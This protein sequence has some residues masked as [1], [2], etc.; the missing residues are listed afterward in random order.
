[1][2]TSQPNA[3][4]RTGSELL[5]AHSLS[6]RLWVPVYDTGPQ[7]VAATYHPSQPHENHRICNAILM[8]AL[9]GQPT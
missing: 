3:N 9:T 6:A 1:M 8:A 7:S 2:V 5:V 4:R